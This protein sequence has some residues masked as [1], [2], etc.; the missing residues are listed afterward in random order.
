MYL[1][2]LTSSLLIMELN[3]CLRCMGWL[4]LLCIT[5]TLVVGFL[6]ILN[7]CLLF[8]FILFILLSTSVCKVKF[9]FGCTLSKYKWSSL[10]CLLFP[11]HKRIMSLTYLC[12]NIILWAFFLI[13]LLTGCSI[14]IMNATW[15]VWPSLWAYLLLLWYVSM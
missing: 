3:A 11:L 5:L 14:A 1:I 12:Q 4:E 2:V 6:Y 9:N 8:V 7:V 13:Y 10:V 15:Y